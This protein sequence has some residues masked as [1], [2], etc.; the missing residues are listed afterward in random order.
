MVGRVA[1]SLWQLVSLS[2]LGI[3]D[4]EFDLGQSIGTLLQSCMKQMVLDSKQLLDRNVNDSSTT[5]HIRN[6]TTFP[7]Y[8]KWADISNIKLE[9]FLSTQNGQSF[10]I[11]ISKVFPFIQ[12]WLAFTI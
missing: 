3:R 10:P 1:D 5:M 4:V 9:L 11:C 2:S 8:P 7:P 6:P 12:N